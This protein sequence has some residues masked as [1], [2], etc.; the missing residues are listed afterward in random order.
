MRTFL[1]ISPQELRKLWDS[2]SPRL[3]EETASDSCPTSPI[4]VQTAESVWKWAE[5]ELEAAN[6]RPVKA[7]SQAERADLQP[8]SVVLSDDLLFAVNAVVGNVTSEVQKAAVRAFLRHWKLEI[9]CSHCK[10]DFQLLGKE[11]GALRRS[12][13]LSAGLLQYLVSTLAAL[14]P[15]YAGR[16]VKQWLIALEKQQN[17][18]FW[19]RQILSN[20]AD[21]SLWVEFAYSD[22]KA[23]NILRNKAFSATP[24]QKL[25]FF[26]H[27]FLR[28]VEKTPLKDAISEIFPA[29]D[30]NETLSAL[31]AAKAA[32]HIYKSA[33]TCEG[34]W[35]LHRVAEAA[36][37]WLLYWREGLEVAWS[38]F[39]TV[40]EGRKVCGTICE[41]M[42]GE[43]VCEQAACLLAYHES[44]THVYMKTD[45]TEKYAE[46]LVAFPRN[47]GLCRAY[48]RLQTQSLLSLTA[49]QVSSEYHSALLFPALQSWQQSQVL[50]SLLSSG[51]FPSNPCS[52]LYLWE[53]WIAGKDAESRALT[54]IRHL[55]FCKS[56]YVAA[57]RV[58]SK[59]EDFIAALSERELH[60]R[61]D[62]FV[63]E[64][65]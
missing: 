46:L 41:G 28:I 11:T 42:A 20:S 60:L 36:A 21:F 51:S 17:S 43:W 14:L 34:D 22:D 12:P 58:V 45:L 55:P 8:N 52:F 57:A 9:C 32:A 62:P 18:Q 2:E 61:V 25:L 31:C 4:P 7:S 39:Q 64:L 1:P 35:A 29:F 6:W 23:W 27:S 10:S 15:V 16:E 40:L 49:L 19:T 63:T 24:E 54:A 37:V 3:G 56:L 53:Q 30:S 33:D 5:K 47:P 26:Y 38:Y 13:E 44:H 48:S 50:T 65:P 59:P